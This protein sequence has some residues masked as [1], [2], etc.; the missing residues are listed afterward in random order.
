MKNTWQVKFYKSGTNNDDFIDKSN[1]CTDRSP[2]NANSMLKKKI[3]PESGFF[4]SLIS[5]IDMLFS[6]FFIGLSFILIFI[7]IKPLFNTAQS[8][9]VNFI[10]LTQYISKLSQQISIILKEH[11][12]MLIL[13][14]LALLLVV[15]ADFFLRRSLKRRGR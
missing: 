7:V 10:D 4:S 5:Q 3:T 1:A 9:I 6:L 2:F 15:V 12:A 8:W 14:G 13:T 11:L